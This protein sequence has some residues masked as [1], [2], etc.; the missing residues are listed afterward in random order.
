MVTEDADKPAGH[1]P[2]ESLIDDLIRDIFSEAG[3]ST[4]ARARGGDPMATLIE[5]AIAS[6]P[7]TTPMASIV[8]K[9]LVTQ[10]LASALADALAPALAEALAPEIMKALE[11][12]P[13]GERT[14]G[15]TASASRQAQPRGG[16]RKA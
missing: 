14:S 5:T 8:E 16:R 7:R 9:L 11:H 6:A 4:K 13:A 3:Q 1:E 10:A 2:V 12:Y 15:E